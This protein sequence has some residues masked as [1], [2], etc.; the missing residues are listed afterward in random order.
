[1]NKVDY[2]IEALEFALE[3]VDRTG[4]FSTDEIRTLAESLE[5]SAEQ[6]GMAFGYDAIPNPLIA[7]IEKLKAA[8]EL[9]IEQLEKRDYIFRKN[10]ADRHGPYVSVNDVHIDGNDVVYDHKGL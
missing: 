9:E 4:A 10:V 8:H 7:E 1:M 2:W 6:Q 5:G 3:D